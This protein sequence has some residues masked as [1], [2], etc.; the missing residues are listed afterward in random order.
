AKLAEEANIKREVLQRRWVAF[1]ARRKV[2]D[3]RLPLKELSALCDQLVQAGVEP[4]TLVP[5]DS[6][7][8]LLMS[9]EHVQASVAALVQCGHIVSPML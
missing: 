6:R 9:Q 4:R 2:G 5:I 1:R 7:S 3:P 8:Y